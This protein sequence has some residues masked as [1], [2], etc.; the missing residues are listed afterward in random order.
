VYQVVSSAP[1]IDTQQIIWI[2]RAGSG[3]PK[4]TDLVRR[5]CYDN[6]TRT[7]CNEDAHL[8]LIVKREYTAP[9]NSTSS[10][11]TLACL[12]FVTNWFMQFG[13][14]FS[15]PGV[16]FLLTSFHIHH[17]YQLTQSGIELLPI[18]LDSAIPP[19]S[20]YHFPM[21]H[22]LVKLYWLNVKRGE[23]WFHC[24]VHDRSASPSDGTMSPCSVTG[25]V[26]SWR[27]CRIHYI[28]II[29]MFGRFIR[30]CMTLIWATPESW[31]RSLSLS[32]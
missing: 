12:L 25:F 2:K 9:Q 32:S 29:V 13:L 14:W 31:W 26:W 1:Q 27:H 23:P 7:I 16:C 10:T 21:S 24:P 5:Y 6:P 28:F 19:Y 3:A 4:N 17:I 11:I 30:P 15:I 18:L 22:Q 8:R 20:P